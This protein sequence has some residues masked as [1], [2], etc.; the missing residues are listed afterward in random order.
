MSHSTRSMALATALALIVTSPA[1]SLSKLEARPEA[2]PG[3]EAEPGLQVG[4]KA[5]KFSLRDQE[6]KDRSLDEILKKGKV[7]LVFYR[8]ADW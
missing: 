2:E 8:S 5:P 3:S 7:A 6:G 4:A 1:H